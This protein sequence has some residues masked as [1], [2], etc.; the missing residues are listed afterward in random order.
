MKRAVLFILL[1][2]SM[3]V[4]AQDVKDSDPATLADV[5]H[6]FD[7]AATRKQ[8]ETAAGASASVLPQAL[9]PMLMKELPNATDEQKTIVREF[10]QTV[11]K[12]TMKSMPLDDMMKAMAPSYQKQ[13][14]HGDI[15]QLCA[16]YESPIGRKLLEKMPTLSSESM[17]A[18]MPI[19]QS[20]SDRQTVENQQATEEFLRKM[21][22][23]EPSSDKK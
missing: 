10:I 2:S 20:W 9:E 6:F 1:L 8:M 14:T 19:L 5:L 17:K 18:V 15:K 3:T 22:A 4:F 23:T 7:V 16:F 12:N 11:M 13:F 21:K